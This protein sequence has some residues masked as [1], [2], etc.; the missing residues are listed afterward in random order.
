MLFA[1]EQGFA[2]GVSAGTVITNVAT[3][4]FEVDS[5]KQMIV[6][7][8]TKDIVAQLLDVDVSSLDAQG[9]IVKSMQKD[10]VLT[11]KVTNIGNGQD[12]YKL[13]VSHNQLSKFRAKNKR[14]YTDTNNNKSYDQKDTEKYTLDLLED[15][16]AI[17]FIIGD[18]REIN[19][20]KPSKNIIY[21]KAKS[22]IGG[23]GKKGTLYTKKGVKGVDAIDGINGGVGEG[24]S[25]YIFN[26]N[27]DVLLTKS[28]LVHNIY[29]TN[30]AV[31]GA[32]ITYDINVSTVKNKIAKCVEV[33]DFIPKDTEY[34]KNS[35]KIDSKSITDAIDL[36]GGYLDIE[37]NKV[38][39]N[40]E[41]IKYPE[42]RNIRFNVKIR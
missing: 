34:L 31:E 7:N 24:E 23:S 36:D 19:L 21:L 3:L 4:S 13:S 2:K 29:G 15:E 11:F 39:I 10:Q 33:I 27:K 41:Q 20:D 6:S 26:V 1:H 37:E 40:F 38:V 32:I 14:L 22:L 12:R 8:K 35:I 30:E 17:V 16:S 9:V 28:A 42:I 25:A 18:I 5:T